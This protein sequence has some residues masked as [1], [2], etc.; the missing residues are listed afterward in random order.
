MSAFFL[1]LCERDAPGWLQRLLDEPPNGWRKTR[2]TLG[3]DLFVPEAQRPSLRSWN[4][5]SLLVGEAYDRRTGQA[6]TAD[7][8]QQAAAQQ[9]GPS[10]MAWGRFV[11]AAWDGS[12]RLTTLYRDPSGA[13]E[14]IAWR[15][16]HVSLAASALP[17]AFRS[18]WPADLDL[19]VPRLAA[20]VHD[21]IHHLAGAPLTGV[22]SL[23]P[24]QALK[25]DDLV[26]AWRARD[27]AKATAPDDPR[28]TLVEAVQT[29]LAPLAGKRVL[30]E[31]SGGLD[32]A[33]VAGSLQSANLAAVNYYV[34]D[35]QGDERVYARA[36]ADH[37]GLN[38]AE[39]ALEAVPLD[40]NSLRQAEPGLRPCPAAFDQAHAT[41]RAAHALAEKADCVL[42]GQ[43]G[44]DLFFQTPT[45]LIA[46]EGAGR[47]LSLPDL[48]ALCRWCGLSI[49]ELTRR[50]V[51]PP[52]PGSPHLQLLSDDGLAMAATATS[53]PW[54]TNLRGVSRVKQLQIRSLAGALTVQALAASEASCVIHPL[55]SQPVMEACLSIPCWLL[56]KGGRDRAL[57]RSAFADRVAPR[58]L[59]RRSKGRL[60]A[61]YGR[62][63]SRSRQELLA[64][65]LEGQMARHGLLRRDAVEWALQPQSLIWRGGYGSLFN[66]IMTELWLEAWAKRLG[67]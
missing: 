15:K 46:A 35:R 7:D 39:V 51:S 25:G 23:A 11:Y 45:P 3:V 19:D 17:T 64:L 26:Q 47:G 48:L 42:T 50:A 67:R 41:L 8:L 6:R 30:V 33:I 37:L 21:P 66:L 62:R 52:R 20:G 53:H 13:L 9:M 28:Q 34:A 24:G 4:A 36:A 65:L 5:Q 43:G 40:L 31:L 49:Y 54:L 59:A 32:S 55:L 38:L 57:A 63:L 22:T 60:S 61:H 14:A 10:E 12:R 16:D 56:T 44:D 58:V 29:A 27:W 18:A 1:T 2:L